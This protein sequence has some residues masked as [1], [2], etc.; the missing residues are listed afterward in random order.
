MGAR[1]KFWRRSRVP[2]EGSRDEAVS[3]IPV[4]FLE[5]RLQQCQTF[6]I[7]SVNMASRGEVNVSN[8]STS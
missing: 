6:Q 5:S 2:N 8:F 7:R 1:L 4:F 3:G